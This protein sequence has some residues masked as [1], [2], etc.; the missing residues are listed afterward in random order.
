MTPDPRD[1][2]DPGMNSVPT[3]PFGASIK[4]SLGWRSGAMFFDFFMTAPSKT[5]TSETLSDR[6]PSRNRLKKYETAWD[7]PQKVKK[8]QNEQNDT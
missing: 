5:Y 7:L 8:R 4:K 2:G 1:P 3:I 6:S